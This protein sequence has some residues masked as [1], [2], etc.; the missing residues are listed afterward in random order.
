M[1]KVYKHLNNNILRTLLLRL[2]YLSIWV[3]VYMLAIPVGEVFCPNITPN[4]RAFFIAHNERSDF[5]LKI[6]GQITLEGKI[7]PN[8]QKST[9]TPHTKVKRVMTE[10]GQAVIF[11][12]CNFANWSQYF[13]SISDNWWTWVKWFANRTKNLVWHPSMGQCL[14]FSFFMF[15]VRMLDTNW[16]KLFATR[17][18][19]LI[20][21]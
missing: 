8:W 14:H 9:F 18:L 10:S 15:T 20:W 16:V 6:L 21:E 2:F 1:E 13:R 5:P 19:L 4:S 12:C 17:N 3:V 11:L 7:L